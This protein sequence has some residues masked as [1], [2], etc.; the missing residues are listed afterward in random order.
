MFNTLAYQP[1]YNGLVFLYHLLG[2]NLGLAIIAVTL[3]IRFILLPLTLPAMRSAQKIKDLKPKLDELKQK[4]QGDKTALQQAQLKLYKENNINPAA[5]CLPYIVQLVVLIAL[6]R[7]LIDFFQNGQLNGADVDLNFYWMNLGQPDNTYLAPI[8]AGIT[9]LVLAVMILPGSDTA[10]EKAVASIT[11]TKKD[12]KQAEDMS[13]MAQ[14]MQQQ[15]VFIMPAM[16]FFI[17]LKFPS[18]LAL[19]WVITTIFSIV[20]QY[21]I[22]GPGGLVTYLKKLKIIK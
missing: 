18:G 13:Q 3:I 8:I 20:Q 10:A 1:I 19:Y 2:D 12:D 16:T 7:V 15:M 4:H 22:S 14:T 17:A 5:G 11:P 6:Y 21:F 9:Q